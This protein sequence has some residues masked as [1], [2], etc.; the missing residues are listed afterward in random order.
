M[1]DS[2]PYATPKTD[3]ASSGE[4]QSRPPRRAGFAY[5]VVPALFGAVTGG[6][7]LAPFCHCVGD[8]GGHSIGAGMGG[9]AALFVGFALRLASSSNIDS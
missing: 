3:S 5:Y 4:S 2:N 7:F 6:V 1:S 9:L 8:L